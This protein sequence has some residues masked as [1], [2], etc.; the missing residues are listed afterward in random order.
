MP[1]SSK[2]P[3]LSLINREWRQRI[4]R[5]NRPLR[6][7]DFGCAQGFFSL[8]LAEL[9]AT[10]HGIEID[11]R[12]VAL[13]N[14]LA[15]EHKDLKAGF[16]H[17]TIEQIIMSLE[18]DGYDL[19]LGLSVFHHLVG[20]YGI[21]SVQK[22]LSILAVQTAVGIYEMALAVE[23]FHWAAAQPQNPRDLLQG[24]TFVHQFAEHKH[25]VS[26]I[27]RPCMPLATSIV[28]NDWV[29]ILKLKNSY[30]H[31]SLKS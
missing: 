21:Q 30:G 24:Y 18:R 26:P 25:N 3:V 16:E 5:T 4:V 20:R 10:V 1:N 15:A 11:K 31:K 2:F 9:G 12:N 19:V 22:L 6:V 28:L 17:N 13:C 23:P 29:E 8:N 7:L 27:L 14:A